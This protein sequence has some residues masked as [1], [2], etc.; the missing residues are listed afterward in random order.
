MRMEGSGFAAAFFIAGL[1]YRIDAGGM[2]REPIGMQ[3]VRRVCSRI[4]SGITY[5]STDF[6]FILPRTRMFSIST[7]KLKAIAK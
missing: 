6:F 3:T 7:P 5:A 4:G 2:L 1:S